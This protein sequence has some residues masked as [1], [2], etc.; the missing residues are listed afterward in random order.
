MFGR[1]KKA[2][3]AAEGRDVAAL[4]LRAT[5]GPM[6]FAH[7][8]NKVA[9]PGGLA[10]TTGWFESLGLQPAEVH[11]RLAAGTEMAAGVGIVLGVANP[12]PSAA[13]VG[14]MSVAAATDHKGKGF[15]VFKGGW[16]YTA[17]VGGAAVALAALGNGK[18]SIDALVG[19]RR[20]GLRPALFA[21]GVGVANA[22]LLL[23]LCYKPE[24]KAPE[25]PEP[26]A[27]PDETVDA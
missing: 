27:K 20:S 6:L 10:G 26:E 4:V 8:Y 15:F 12:L 3:V 2:P 24:P 23:K 9:G 19:R 16:E 25:A 22:A 7:G 17:V 18:Y 21:A 13:T 11:A 14:L 1:K 5:L